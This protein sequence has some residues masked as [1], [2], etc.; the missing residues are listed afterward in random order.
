M[1][2]VEIIKIVSE[3]NKISQW[4][5]TK[6]VDFVSYDYN[7]HTDYNTLF[8]SLVIGEVIIHLELFLS[9]DETD[10]VINCYQDK[11]HILSSMGTT[12]E[13]LKAI[14]KILIW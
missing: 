4:F 9:D 10:C 14:D 13:C 6:K 11:A 7:E 12:E 2:K 3:L 5:I 1:A 8:I